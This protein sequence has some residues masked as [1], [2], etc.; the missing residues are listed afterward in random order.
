MDKIFKTVQCLA[1][2]NNDRLE[3]KISTPKSVRCMYQVVT[4]RIFIFYSQAVL[5]EMKELG[6]QSETARGHASRFGCRDNFC[7]V[8]NSIVHF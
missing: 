8:P 1:L 6:M 3:W 5:K 2:W 7:F 4:N